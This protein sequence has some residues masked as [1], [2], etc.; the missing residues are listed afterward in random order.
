M[1]GGQMPSP[2][3]IQM[4][5]R[6]I[7]AEAQKA[8]MSVPDFVE[9]VKKQQM[10]RMQQ[11][12]AAAAAGGAPPGT[13]PANA[14]PGTPG[15]AAARPGPPRPGAP[16]PGQAKPQPITPGPPNPKALAVANF[17]KGQDLKPRMCILNGE[18]KD[19]FKGKSSTLEYPRVVEW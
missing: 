17:L 11:Q 2:E 14:A 13:S 9:H 5:Q 6:Q 8:G 3:Q 1:P 16:R 19:M 10:M 7:A 12:R 4:M 15:A 18:R